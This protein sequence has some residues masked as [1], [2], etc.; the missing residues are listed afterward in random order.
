[1]P[2]AVSVAV[3]ISLLHLPLKPG[4]FRAHAG[5]VHVAISQSCQVLIPQHV[6]AVSYGLLHLARPFGRS[7]APATQASLADR[8]LIE[9]FLYL[10]TPFDVRQD[11]RPRARNA[12]FMLIRQAKDHDSSLPCSPPRDFGG[13]GAA[14]P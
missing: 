3:G 12:R 4:E 5:R 1:M 9:G 10:S 6:R 11:S 8:M 2:A 7:N 14:S 13:A